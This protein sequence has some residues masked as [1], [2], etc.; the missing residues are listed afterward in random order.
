MNASIPIALVAILSL[1]SI[2]SFASSPK[3]IYGTDDRKDLYQVTNPL[4]LKFADSTV[5]LVEAESVTQN[6]SGIMNI[7]GLTLI[8]AINVCSTE[9]FATQPTGAFCSGSLVGKNVILTAGHCITSQAECNTTKFVFG[10]AITQA[11]VFPTTAKESE[12]YG[13]KS[14]LHREQNASGADFGVILLDRDVTNHIPL[15]L[16]ARTV[17]APITNGSKLLFIGNP[18][19]LPTKL[20]DGGFVRDGTQNGFFVATIDSYGGSSGAPVLNPTTGEIEGILARG[21]NDYVQKGSCYVSNV[22]TAT[23][24]RGQDVTKASSMAAYIPR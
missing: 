11:G 6:A 8:D 4:Y 21:E 24:C 12:V 22:C 3:V 19:G 16:S 1:T 7:V 9:A 23:S 13:C 5:A 14:I 10:Y 2:S 20:D 17:A 15:K 18:S